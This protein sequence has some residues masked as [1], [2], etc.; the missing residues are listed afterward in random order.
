MTDQTR[1]RLA[2]GL[3]AALLVLWGLVVCAGPGRADTLRANV[4]DPVPSTDPN[5]IRPVEFEAL[6]LGAWVPVSH[7]NVPRPP[8]YRPEVRP[9]SVTVPQSGCVP[10]RAYYVLSDGG[11][12]SGP[13]NVVTYCPTPVPTLAC[14]A[15][16][17]EDGGVGLDDVG[18]VFGQAAQGARCP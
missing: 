10:L 12:L 17:N 2:V 8:S 14:R 18:I 4:E 6:V 11:R 13:S 16:L 9:A 7:T 5:G 1:S 3:G 15:D